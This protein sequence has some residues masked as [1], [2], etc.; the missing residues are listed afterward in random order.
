MLGR[1]EKLQLD[2]VDF[3]NFKFIQGFGFA[4]RLF[5]MPGSFQKPTNCYFSRAVAG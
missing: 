5:L 2:F 4:S 3:P 1:D